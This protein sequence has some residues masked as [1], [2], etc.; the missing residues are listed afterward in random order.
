M[1]AG[2]FLLLCYTTAWASASDRTLSV[3]GVTGDD[4]PVTSP[5]LSPHDVLKPVLVLLRPQ[6][7]APAGFPAIQDLSFATTTEP[8]MRLVRVEHHRRMSISQ[9]RL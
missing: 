1:V 8:A 3:A 4:H 7:P 5:L 9:R 6:P 2:L